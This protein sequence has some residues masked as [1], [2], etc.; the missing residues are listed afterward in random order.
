[1]RIKLF[2]LAASFIIII[3]C[4]GDSHAQLFPRFSLAGGP[5]VGWFYNN[6]DDINTQMRL[7][8][9]PEFPKDGFLTLGGGGFVDLPLKNIRWLRVGGYGEGFT[10][11]RQH[12]N[13]DVTQTVYYKYT[14][15]GMTLDYVK[16]FGKVVELTIGTTLSTGK[17][18]IE[19]YK[20]NP[21]FGSWNGIWNEIIPAGSTEN[22]NHKLSVRYYA[23]KPQVGLGVFLTSYLY[24]KLNVGYQFSTMGD[25]EVDDEIPVTNA[26]SGI[27]ADGLTFNFGL[28]FGIFTK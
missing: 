21:G 5:T 23:A 7:I 9:V 18:T 11:K 10:S 16:P 2:S 22:V 27:K 1:M 25:W 12:T 28:N 19:L 4:A 6:T 20:N 8:G 14:S 3:T 13:A 26:P 15:G 17:L 24:A